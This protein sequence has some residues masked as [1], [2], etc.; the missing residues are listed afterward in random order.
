MEVGLRAAIRLQSESER[1]LFCGTDRSAHAGSVQ[2]FMP[3]IPALWEAEVGGS[4]EV[5]SL[6]LAWST[7][8]NSASTKNTKFSQAWWHVPV[9]L[10]TMGAEATEVANLTLSPRLE[11]SGTISAHCSLCLLGSIDSPASAS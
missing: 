1:F 2:W 5:R 4:P 3:V 11:C 6:R 9:I 10:A 7:R 8:Q